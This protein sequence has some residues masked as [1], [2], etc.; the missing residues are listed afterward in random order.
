MTLQAHE[1]AMAALLEVGGDPTM[2]DYTDPH[3]GQ[4]VCLHTT[5]EALAWKA[6]CVGEMS[7]FGPMFMTSCWPCFRDGLAT[8]GEACTPVRDAIRGITCS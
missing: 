2:I 7:I 5:D 3:D 1:V 6:C 4:V 8:Q